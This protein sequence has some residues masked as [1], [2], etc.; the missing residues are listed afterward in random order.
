MVQNKKA[1]P[2]DSF[3]MTTTQCVVW[4]R[5]CAATLS[6]ISNELPANGLETD[7][8]ARFASVIGVEVARARLAV[9]TIQGAAL[10][11]DTLLQRFR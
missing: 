9:T 6:H 7:T 3:P 1:A 2:K 11:D 10:A 5:G 8:Q 4:L